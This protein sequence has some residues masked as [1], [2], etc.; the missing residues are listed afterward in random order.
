MPCLVF[1]NR[2][3]T[4]YRH[5]KGVNHMSL[6]KK[7]IASASA[8]VMAFS[9]VPFTV[10][11]S[12]APD[13]TV[14]EH[15]VSEPISYKYFNTVDEAGEYL[16]GELKLHKAE[17]HIRLSRDADSKDILN[18]IL[19][20]ALA[21]TGEPTEGDFMRLV[22]EGYKV[23][24]GKINYDPCID[25]I[26]YYN[27]TYEQDIAAK[28]IS[29][30]LVGEF[31]ASHPDADNYDK[32]SYVYKYL[33]E[34]V[35][36]STDLTDESYTSYGALVNHDAVCQGFVQAM[37]MMLKSMDVN[38]R[39]VIGKGNGN[40]H[41]WL[42]AEIDG[43]YYYLDPTWDSA[44]KGMTYYFFLKGTKDFDENANEQLHFAGSGD[45]RNTALVPDCTPEAFLPE[46]P[47]SEYKYKIPAEK[48]PRKAGDIN[49]DGSIDVFDLIAAKK[50]LI[51][52]YLSESDLISADTDGNGKV[53]I[54]DAVLL[55]KY[56][57]GS[58]SSF[59]TK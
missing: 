8:L 45:E 42:I 19:S 20:S 17:I 21:E 4:Q 38:C 56:I 11:A 51:Q 37:Y 54:N 6:S 10:S 22:I 2:A 44:Y 49:N 46:Y 40:D 31:M 3:N 43:K 24:T 16:R 30:R 55:Q 33:T 15:T 14:T 36:Y 9:A 58:I 7:M 12:Y 59:N 1:P 41:V 25:M 48:S 18:D 52:G 57:H 50:I 39:A 13:I 28:E 53:S 47:I 32:I 26:L 29:D 35:V 34:N 23:S 5:L 27:S